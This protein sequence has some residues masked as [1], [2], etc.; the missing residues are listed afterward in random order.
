MH[1][2]SMVHFIDSFMN[3]FVHKHIEYICVDNNVFHLLLHVVL[4]TY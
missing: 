2:E 4:I 1:D 3:P